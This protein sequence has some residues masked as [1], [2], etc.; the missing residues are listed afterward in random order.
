MKQ[1]PLTQ[2]Q[3]AFVDDEDFDKVSAHKWI[4]WKPI[5]NSTFYSTRR[6]PVLGHPIYMH[7]FILGLRK[8]DKTRVDHVDG[9]GLNNTRLNLRT[10]FHSQNLMNRGKTR[11][12]TSGFKGVFFHQ[13]KPHHT[14]KWRSMIKPGNAKPIHLGC[15]D[16]REEA[17]LAYNAAAVKYHGEFARLNSIP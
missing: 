9:N 3:V 17:A 15:F 11:A 14:P 7:R 13:L 2:N 16:T 12:N 8:G 4:A 6:C 1:I 10:C 5:P